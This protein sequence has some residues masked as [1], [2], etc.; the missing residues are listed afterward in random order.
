M[1]LPRLVTAIVIVWIGHWLQ[2]ASVDQPSSPPP[3]PIS[4][5][6]AAISTDRVILVWDTIP[7]A[8]SFVIERSADGIAGWSTIG[9]AGA[10]SV[11]FTDSTVTPSTAYHY[12]LLPLIVGSDPAVGPIGPI[13]VP[14]RDLLAG[15]LLSGSSLDLF[16]PG[17][18][19]ALARQAD[20]KWIAAGQFTYVNGVA[21]KNIARLNADGSL[22]A[23][24]DPGSGPNGRVRSLAIQSDGKIVI[25]GEFTAVNGISRAQVA[26]LHVSGTIDSGFTSPFST[27]PTIVRAILILADGRII[28]GGRFDGN[29]DV[30]RLSANGSRD[31]SY[32]P[33]FFAESGS[34]STISVNALALQTDGKV[35]AGGNFYRASNSNGSGAKITRVARINSDGTIDSTFAE[36]QLTI[37]GGPIPVGPGSADALALQSDGKVMVGGD[38]SQI[39]SQSTRFLAR[40]NS[41]GSRD[42]SFVLNSSSPTGKVLS[43]AILADGR[44]AVGGHFFSFGAVRRN[45]FAV[46]SASAGLLGSDAG[47]FSRPV[48]A[49]A[50]SSGGGCLVGGS[51]HQ[52]NGARSQSLVHISS[53][54]SNP[55]PSFQATF[56]QS[57]S[58][59]ALVKQPD[60]KTVV[61]GHF[62]TIG[63]PD[64]LGICRAYVLRLSADDSL[65]ASFGGTALFDPPPYTGAVGPDG[66]VW[67]GG[68]FIAS[69]GS[70]S[71]YVTR[72][73]ATGGLEIDPVSGPNTYIWTILAEADGG[74]TIGGNFSRVGGEFHPYIAR[75]MADGSVGPDFAVAGLDRWVS[76]L[77]R[78]SDGKLLMRGYFTT[79]Y[80][81]PITYL[82]RLDGESL[83]T[84]FAPAPNA[85]VYDF[86]LMPDGRILVAGIFST[87]GG[88][89]RRLLARLL[90]NGQ[91]D[92][93]FLS[94]LDTASS[95]SS[96]FATEGGGCLVT[97]SLSGLISGRTLRVAKLRSEGAL[98]P[99]FDIG[100]NPDQTPTRA[101]VS[102][103]RILFGGSFTTFGG[104]PRTGLASVRA[105]P[106]L[107]RPGS[108]TP[109]ILSATSSNSAS[110]GWTATSGSAGYL[111]ERSVPGSA[112]WQIVGLRGAGEATF[113][114]IGLLPGRIWRYRVSAF[115][116]AG[117]SP[118]SNVVIAALPTTFEQW[119]LDWGIDPT[120]A[121]D[122]DLDRDGLGILAEYGGG[123]SP[124][125]ADA[126]AASSVDLA[127]GNLTLTYFRAR[128]DVT[129]IVQVSSNLSGWTAE[130]VDQ[131][132]SGPW[133]TASVPASPETEKF[134]RLV[135][136]QP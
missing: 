33:S 131:G 11:S 15:G 3:P 110:L 122:A 59:S 50:A 88:A 39:G 23:T 98:D 24:F 116:A 16:R 126:E 45:A 121:P 37:N 117:S 114:D 6:A 118:T 36:V 65:D 125:A 85:D 86:D 102:S 84:T 104:Q 1:I 25:G 68:S 82:A 64:P 46:L 72:L 51:F 41:D 99:E 43:I 81:Q 62:T 101:V 73:T 76:K 7:A 92:P 14:G 56:S 90:G 96:V 55:D 21:R 13:A 89:P 26:R 111:V 113:D 19:Y 100:S 112:G 105:V 135:V 52:A 128:T 108:P 38:F 94:S 71:D 87:I 61:I 69:Y 103:Q 35:L 22:D 18:V 127:D 123:L 60:G 48:F 34:S 107:A 20:G 77:M 119:R 54:G 53:D 79:V 30:V 115:N 120:A 74:A 132:G 130:G 63:G 78:Q 27:A 12:R 133:V 42:P 2:A 17:D 57:G 91:N 8:T 136:S 49:I 31:F 106:A 40:L 97:G 67:V 134:L 29:A 58:V 95:V 124:T 93:Q 75:L 109:L 129:Y 44:I 47:L 32:A 80:S 66:K 10:G 28:L 5:N 83:D 4:L 70:P 9:S